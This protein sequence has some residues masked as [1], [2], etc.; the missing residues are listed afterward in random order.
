MKKAREGNSNRSMSAHSAQHSHPVAPRNGTPCQ[1]LQVFAWSLPAPTGGGGELCPAGARSLLRHTS[2]GAHGRYSCNSEVPTRPRA[3]A[4]SG[5]RPLF[6]VRRTAR[7][8]AGHK[9]RRREGGVSSQAQGFRPSSLCSPKDSQGSHRAH[10]GSARPTPAG[11]PWPS[12]FQGRKTLGAAR[13]RPENATGTDRESQAEGA[14]CKGRR[15]KRPVL[16]ES[17]R[18]GY[19]LQKCTRPVESPTSDQH[20]D[21]VRGGKLITEPKR[22]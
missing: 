17:L 13:N 12:I 4:S 21:W 19:K 18:N 10:G 22:M 16:T 7:A 8:R 11:V 14:P 20:E 1:N 15:E 9:G 3:L 5:V 2:L 6:R